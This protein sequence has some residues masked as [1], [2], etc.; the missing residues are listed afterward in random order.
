MEKNN[1]KDFTTYAGRVNRECERFKWGILTSDLFKCLIFAWGLTAI[2]DTE[3]RMKILTKLEMNQDITL[4]K[5]LED[6]NMILKVR[7]DTEEIQCRDCL[8]IKPVC[9]SWKTNKV[10]H[11]KQQKIN[12]CMACGGRHLRKECPFKKAKCFHC[13]N[14]GH[15][16]L[17]C[18]TKMMK[19][20]TKQEK[21]NSLSSEKK[22]CT[23]NRKSIKV[24]IE[25]TCVKMQLDMGSDVTIINEETW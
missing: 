16:K 6:C 13:L 14:T 3:V 25:T 18:R 4:R 20:W 10:F 22:V 12:P 11:D 7:H 21:I 9:K 23:M 1:Y 15:I 24:R 8:Q 2:K 19:N 17:H 5:L